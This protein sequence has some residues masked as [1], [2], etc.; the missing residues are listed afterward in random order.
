MQCFYTVVTCFER[1][2][3]LFSYQR[4]LSIHPLPLLNLFAQFNFNFITSN[5]PMFSDERSGQANLKTSFKLCKIC[6]KKCLKLSWHWNLSLS[7]STLWRKKKIS[8]IDLRCSLDVKMLKNYDLWNQ[9]W[10]VDFA[11]HYGKYSNS[12]FLIKISL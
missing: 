10:K 4:N 8:L 6:H 7:F 9:T 12:I 3:L 11:F 5:L 1:V 2:R